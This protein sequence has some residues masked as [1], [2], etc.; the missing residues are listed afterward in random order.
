MAVLHNP[1]RGFHTFFTN[2]TQNIRQIEQLLLL[3]RCFSQT[4]KQLPFVI[5]P[6]KPIT[7]G[8]QQFFDAI[9][10]PVEALFG[11]SIC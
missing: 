11:D 9:F 4:S 8:I 5:K 2:A 10:S 1:C 3:L 6:E 7:Q